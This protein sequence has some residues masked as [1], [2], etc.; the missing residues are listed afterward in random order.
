MSLLG[1]TC[2]LTGL[3]ID[4]I[5]EYGISALDPDGGVTWWNPGAHRISG[6]TEGG[7]SRVLSPG[8]GAEQIACR[9]LVTQRCGRVDACRPV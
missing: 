8:W 7:A 9:S 1:A 6:Y 5:D 4:A 3:L 2:G